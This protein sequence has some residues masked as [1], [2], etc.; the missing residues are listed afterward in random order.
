M[1]SSLADAEAGHCEFVIRVFAD[2][3]KLANLSA[4]RGQRSMEH[5]DCV[6]DFIAGFNAAN[7]SSEFVDVGPRSDAVIDKIT[8]MKSKSTRRQC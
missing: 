4:V 6:R 1:Y 3:R 7:S 8:G 5:L 2:A